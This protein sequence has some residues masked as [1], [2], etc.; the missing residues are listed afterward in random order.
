MSIFCHETNLNRLLF[1]FANVIKMYQNFFLTPTCKISQLSLSLYWNEYLNAIMSSVYCM[2]I[3]KYIQVVIVLI[4]C[5][6][7]S[8]NKK[9]F[10][11]HFER[12]LDFFWELIIRNLGETAIPDVLSI[13]ES[14]QGTEIKIVD[15]FRPS[16]VW[17]I[18][19][20]H[21]ALKQCPNLN[22]IRCFSHV[23]CICN[24]P[25]WH[26]FLSK[27]WRISTHDFT[28]GCKPVAI[29]WSEKKKFCQWGSATYERLRNAVFAI[30]ICR[31]SFDSNL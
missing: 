25:H 18:C 31:S 12:I 24:F 6:I 9:F 13:N 28:S 26:I 19:P 2:F 30:P 8:E 7:I 4:T 22:R 23:I 14:P 11:N 21:N 5:V 27:F 3:V 20:K 29:I 15:I 10:M 16:H 1:R 17:C